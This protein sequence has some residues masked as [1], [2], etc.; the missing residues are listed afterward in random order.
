[1]NTRKDL[2]IERKNANKA[3]DDLLK[4]IVIKYGEIVNL[5]PQYSSYDNSD[6]YHDKK[7]YNG[8]KIL[9]NLKSIKDVGNGREKQN[10]ATFKSFLRREEMILDLIIFEHQSLFLLLVEKFS[11]LCKD[12][13]EIKTNSYTFQS[14]SLLSCIL[15]LLINNLNV[16]KAGLKLGYNYQ[17]NIIFRNYIELSEIA[18]SVITSES[19]YNQ[20]TVEPQNENQAKNKWNALKPG[21]IHANVNKEYLKIERFESWGNVLDEV[22][23]ALYNKT[24]KYVHCDVSSII[25]ETYS[26]KLN[27]NDMS[28]TCYGEI[29]ENLRVT[30]EEVIIYSKI[31]INDILIFLINSHKLGLIR[32]G[33]YGLDH[34]YLRAV[35]EYIYRD[36]LNKISR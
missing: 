9:K 8:E 15:N 2:I 7:L 16:I 29:G 34:G 23:S 14:L 18:I 36:F 35:N 17:V 33:Q 6:L 24:S 31:V 19:F 30:F 10:Y 1:M 22:R 4:E 27:Q 5:K 11:P 3:I 26:K 32:F 13:E 21:K 28:V 20:Y 12:F 25:N